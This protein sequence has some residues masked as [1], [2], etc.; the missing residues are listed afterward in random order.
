MVRFF[1]SNLFAWPGE[2]QRSRATA[3]IAN[4]F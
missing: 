1:M 3:I 4:H 2:A